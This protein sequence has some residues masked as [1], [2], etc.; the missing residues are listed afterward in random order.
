MPNAR[1]LKFHL[2]PIPVSQPNLISINIRI[3]I[4]ISELYRK[5]KQIF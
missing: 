3:N 1:K 4:Q 5:L 2:T